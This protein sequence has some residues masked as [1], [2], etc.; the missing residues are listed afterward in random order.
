MKLFRHI[1]LTFC[2]GFVAQKSSVVGN[3]YGRSGVKIFFAKK[4]RQS[5]HIFVH[6]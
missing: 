6:M 4:K 1:K 3:V 5:C 2:G